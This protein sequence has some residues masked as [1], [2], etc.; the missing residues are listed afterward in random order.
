MNRPESSFG[1]QPFFLDL[2]P[3]LTVGAGVWQLS[4]SH[5]GLRVRVGTTATID[6]IGFSNRFID[7][8][9][10]ATL[11]GAT[12]GRVSRAYDATDNAYDGLAS[13]TGAFGAANWQAYD[14]TAINTDGNGNQTLK[15]SSTD[16]RFTFS[17]AIAGE[18]TLSMWVEPTSLSGAAYLF[19]T[20][21]YGKSGKR[22][23]TV[24]RNG[25]TLQYYDYNGSTYPLILSTASFFTLE[26]FLL[27]VT[28]QSDNKIRVYKNGVL[29]ATSAGTTT[30]SYNPTYLNLGSLRGTSV[31]TGSCSLMLLFN[32]SQTAKLASIHSNILSAFN[33]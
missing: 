30:L 2:F 14:G 25:S 6:D 15:F 8:A 26:P 19:A 28:R 1:G 33:V 23:F 4:P 13:G 29:I 12:E 9:A 3:D 21:S 27:T 22:G 31:F 24:Y 20:E 7:E 16:Q 11:C 32:N 5:L 10:L 17:E 18:F